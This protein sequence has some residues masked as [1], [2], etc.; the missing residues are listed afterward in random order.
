MDRPERSLAALLTLVPD[1]TE[2]RRRVVLNRYDPAWTASGA[3][4]AATG[5][6]L[7]DASLTLTNSSRSKVAVQAS[8]FF[9]GSRM[10]TSRVQAAVGYDPRRLT[11]DITAGAPPNVVQVA[12]GSF[13]Q[14]AVQRAVRASVGGKASVVQ[15]AG[16]PVI[17]WLDDLRI[18]VEL[19]GKAPFSD[20]G[21]AG[22]V[23]VPDAGTLVL[24]RTD[25]AVTALI[26]R[27]HGRG[28]SLAQNAGLKSVAD[29]LDGAGVF[30]A[31]LSTERVTA[32]SLTRRRRPASPRSYGDVAQPPYVAYGIGQAVDGGRSVLVVAFAHADDAAAKTGV[33]R[34]NAMVAQG[35]SAATAR[36]WTQ[37]LTSPQV[38]AAGRVVVGRFVVENPRLWSGIDQQRDSLL[39]ST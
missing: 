13:D 1:S 29:A 15:L 36:P 38:K 23:A 4:R 35:Q 34:L 12:R 18:D 5:D 2:Q 7:D 11:A 28:R 16:A 3:D 8:T 33:E 22:R 14:G 6:A 25:A 17:R 19:A 9:G 20:V 39:L 21:Q 31:V 26:E 10:R 30:S 32:E 24:A 27:T 37:L